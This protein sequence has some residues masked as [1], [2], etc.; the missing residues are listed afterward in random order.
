MS[1][2]IAR[3]VI[4]ILDRNKNRLDWPDVPPAAI[5]HIKTM[6]DLAKQLEKLVQPGPEPN[7]LEGKALWE[8]LAH[9][10]VGIARAKR[11][12][13]LTAKDLKDLVENYAPEPHMA[14]WLASS[15]GSV[16]GL[17]RHEPQV[18][19]L[20]EVQGVLLW[21]RWEDEQWRIVHTRWLTAVADI[22]R[23]VLTEWSG[24]RRCRFC[25][26]SENPKVNALESVNPQHRHG[27][28]MIGD[29]VVLQTGGVVTHDA[30]RKYWIAWTAIA[31]KY[32]S[33]EEAVA[34]DKAAGRESRWA[35]VVERAA[36][37]GPANG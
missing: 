24:G 10:I 22:R 26:C 34:A 25:A 4:L 19:K 2:A 18:R 16:V 20:I 21:D 37:E 3:E 11:G 14:F 36:L 29:T 30:C 17:L 15:V 35:P 9:A 33:N 5:A 32:S 8:S 27:V 12:V 23:W 6:R 28:Q 1:T 7:F 13:R 31:A